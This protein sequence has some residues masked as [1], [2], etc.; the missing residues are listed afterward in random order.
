[1]C[2]G[3]IEASYEKFIGDIPADRFGALWRNM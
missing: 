1:M 3:H 2:T